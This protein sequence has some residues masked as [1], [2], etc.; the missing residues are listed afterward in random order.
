MKPIIASVL[1]ALMTLA[2]FAPAWAQGDPADDVFSM[3]DRA[4]V[5]VEQLL[6]DLGEGANGAQL[7]S[8]ASTALV[9]LLTVEEQLKALDSAQWGKVREHAVLLEAQA[10]AGDTEAMKATAPALLQELDVLKDAV[11]SWQEEGV[12][13]FIQ[14]YGAYTGKEIAIPIQVEKVPSSGI[15]AFELA[16]R[17][18]SETVEVTA[19]KFPLG[20]GEKDIDN[21]TGRM[22]LRA[23]D[24]GLKGD[25]QLE[26]TLAEV[27]FRVIGKERDVCLISFERGDVFDLEGDV[28]PS[29]SANGSLRVLAGTDS[30]GGGTVAGQSG[31]HW[32]LIVLFSVIGAVVAGG[33]IVI[34]SR[35]VFAKR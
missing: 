7:Y 25:G 21:E 32:S 24:V 17:F 1:L 8:E 34:G 4:Q 19:V 35:L 15:S 16:L 31:L 11:M 6:Q 22:M 3:V 20:D 2:T 12:A 29:T 33:L 5:Q 30:G 27:V 26:Q 14:D 9:Y 13:I 18:T 28:I 23:S 10:E